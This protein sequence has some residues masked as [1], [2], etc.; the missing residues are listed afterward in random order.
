MTHDGL[1]RINR[2]GKTITANQLFNNLK[3][4]AYS[5]T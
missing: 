4:G 3:L 5:L 2:F 1:G